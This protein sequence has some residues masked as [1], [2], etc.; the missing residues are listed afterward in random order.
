MW[1]ADSLEK[2]LMLE[3]I[4]GRRRKGWQ[5]MRWLHSI[6]DSMDVSLSKLQEMVKDREARWSAVPGVTKSQTQLSDWITAKEGLPF[7]PLSPTSP[8]K[9]A[10][11]RRWPSASQEERPHK[12]LT[13]QIPWFQAS[14]WQNCET[15]DTCCLSHPVCGICYGS[16]SWQRHLGTLPFLLQNKW[17]PV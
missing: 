16:P 10:H 5:R 4:E 15:I 11:R 12:H 17:E 2:T 6:I 3:K 8:I 7:V 14:S 1:R 9:W 13:V